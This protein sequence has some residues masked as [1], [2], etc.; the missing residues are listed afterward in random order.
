MTS[1]TGRRDAASEG[2]YSALRR[3]APNLV[4]DGARETNDQCGNARRLRCR[5]SGP[6]G[7]AVARHLA[8][9]GLRVTAIGRDTGRLDLL[10]A[11]IS[12]HRADVRDA[13]AIGAALASSAIVVSCVH[14]RFTPA[15]LTAATHAGARRIVLL[16]STRRFSAV[17][18]KGATATV[19]AEAAFREGTL[20]GFMMHSTLIYGPGIASNLS[21]IA[22]L[23]DRHRIVPLPGSGRARLQPVHIDDVAA[24]LAAAVATPTDQHEILVLAGAA[25]LSW[26]DMVR[27][28][29]LARGERARILPLPAGLVTPLARLA[30]RHTRLPR[31]LLRAAQRMADDQS[32]NVAPLAARLG[33]RTMDVLSG[34]MRTF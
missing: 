20:P 32:Y 21:R 26:R 4:G 2:Q 17:P 12:R 15:L 14:S 13:T 33:I 25:A 19:V 8:S 6:I 16:S 24:A 7:V 9:L 23:I 1:N 10:P 30:M 22:G 29:A 34:V 18:D 28:I 11:S 3:V 27:L 31:S 5:A